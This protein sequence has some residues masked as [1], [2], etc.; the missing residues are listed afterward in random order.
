MESLELEMKELMP[1]S[2]LSEE[3]SRLNFE[4][5]NYKDIVKTMLQPPLNSRGGRCGLS[6][7]EA[8]K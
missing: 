8:L 1:S 6:R 5:S 4:L 2:G 7:K 3:F